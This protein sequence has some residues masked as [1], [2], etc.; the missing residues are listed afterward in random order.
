V[1]DI[2]KLQGVWQITSLEI[3]GNVLSA[4]ALSGATIAIDGDKFT[5]LGMGAIYEGTLTL[6][7]KA[8]P[9]AFDM[10]FTSGPE[11]GNSN[12]GIYELDRDTWRICLNTRG[13]KR[14]E[15]FAAPPGTGFAVE[16]LHR[17]AGA[18]ASAK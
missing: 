15:K 18:A 6:D 4:A 2:Q 5:S 17:S 8:T 1:S 9:K 12:A 7:A 14:P 10:H 11:K 16:V 13:Q 3:D